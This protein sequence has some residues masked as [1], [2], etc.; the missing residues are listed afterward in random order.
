MS[1][2]AEATKASDRN[3][4]WGEGRD[5][6]EATKLLTNYLRCGSL[7]GAFVALVIPFDAFQRLQGNAP[8]AFFVDPW[9]RR[10][11]ELREL[12]KTIRGRREAQIASN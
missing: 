8:V 4:P 2:G 5:F 1:P 3:S 12:Q 11:W 7:G 9:P 6:R 10:V